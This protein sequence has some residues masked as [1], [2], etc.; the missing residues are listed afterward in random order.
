MCVGKRTENG[1]HEM[2]KKITYSKQ[3]VGDSGW[4]QEL[5]VEVVP[6]VS[7]RLKG[8][9]TNKVNGPVSFDKTFAIGD[10]AEYDSYNLSYIGTI[11]AIG[12]KTVTIAPRYGGRKYRLSLTNFTWR[13]RDFDAAVIAARNL[14]ISY[15][16]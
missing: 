2:A 3:E 10:T 5:T 16:I 1:E 11:V 15:T 7:I 6:G 14:E 9:D 13:N 8:I 4:A 12:K